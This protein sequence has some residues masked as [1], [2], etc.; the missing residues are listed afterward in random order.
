VK[1]GKVAKKEKCRRGGSREKKRK[2]GKEMST[3]RNKKKAA[4]RR[5]ERKT[6]RSR[7]PEWQKETR[8]SEKKRKFA[9]PVSEKDQGRKWQKNWKDKRGELLYQDYFDIVIDE[10][11]GKMRKGVI[12]M[13]NLLFKINTCGA[14]TP[15]EGTSPEPRRRVAN[16]LPELVENKEFLERGET[17]SLHGGY[18]IAAQFNGSRRKSQGGVVENS[19]VGQ[20]ALFRDAGGLLEVETAGRKVLISHNNKRIN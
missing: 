14:R 20:A 1:K 4:S 9:T 7:D 5:G 8:M 13:A 10:N 16:P 19:V 2:I 11:R 18:Y 3:T 12:R 17:N 6:V 15:E